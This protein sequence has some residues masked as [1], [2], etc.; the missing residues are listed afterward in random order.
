MLTSTSHCRLD[1]HVDDK[2][3]SV[4]ATFELP[5]LKKED[6]NIEILNGV[7]TVSGE[8]KREESH[9]E[10]GYS[11]RGRSFGKFSRSLQLPKGVKVS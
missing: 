7:L 1:L 5:G 6:V 2:A 3:N 11:V 8:S 4:T 9:E 10:S